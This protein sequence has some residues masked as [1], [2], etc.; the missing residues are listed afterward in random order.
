MPLVGG[1]FLQFKYSLISSVILEKLVICLINWYKEK[2]LLVSLWGKNVFWRTV[3]RYRIL[4]LA[5]TLGSKKQSHLWI[6]SKLWIFP[7]WCKIHVAWTSRKKLH[8]AA[9][10]YLP[11]ARDMGCKF[12]SHWAFSSSESSSE[13]THWTPAP[14]KRWQEAVEAL[15]ENIYPVRACMS[16]CTWG[17]CWG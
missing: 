7:Q 2:S 16:V 12:P 17:V 13:R 15:A 1:I 8:L 6:T 14:F 11:N 4:I 10:G 9:T 3:S 5:L